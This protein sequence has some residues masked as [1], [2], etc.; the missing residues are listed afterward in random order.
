MRR[1][2]IAESVAII[3]ISI[4]AAILTWIFSHSLVIAVIFAAFAILFV[5][6]EIAG[7]RSYWKMPFGLNM[8]E[9]YEFSHSQFQRIAKSFTTLNVSLGLVL[10][11][12][13]FVDSNLVLIDSHYTNLVPWKAMIMMFAVKIMAWLFSAKWTAREKQL[14]LILED[15]KE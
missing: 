7:F 15:F 12:I 11:V 6:I 14:R 10:L 8:K 3:A 13:I 9:M 1:Q 2:L 4:A 5:G